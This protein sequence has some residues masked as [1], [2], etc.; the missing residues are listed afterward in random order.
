[1]QNYCIRVNGSV[2]KRS[3]DPYKLINWWMDNHPNEVLEFKFI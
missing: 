3:T 1:M 2:V